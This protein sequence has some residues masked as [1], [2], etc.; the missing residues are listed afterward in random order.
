MVSV[1]IAALRSIEREKEIPFETVM[2]ALETALLTAYRH[3][4]HPMPNARVDID[5]KSGA[6]TVWPPEHGP[7]GELIEE[8]DDTP[9]DF[10]R[11]PTIPLHH[12]F[13]GFPRIETPSIWN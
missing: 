6:V 1:D 4:N 12:V 3:T 5:R 8:F 7:D 10:G 11:F 9:T 2:E 13:T